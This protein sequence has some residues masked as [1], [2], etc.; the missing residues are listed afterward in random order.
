ML[1]AALTTQTVAS[2][3]ELARAAARLV[4]PRAGVVGGATAARLATAFGVLSS[5]LVKRPANP[6][7][8]VSGMLGNG[9]EYSEVEG[10]GWHRPSQVISQDPQDG[11]R[12]SFIGT[13]PS[14]YKGSRWGGVHR[15]TAM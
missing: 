4:A 5:M 1:N 2:T 6:C 7:D 9:V 8:R 15:E 12:S 3:A 10:L 13:Q 14:T 11:S